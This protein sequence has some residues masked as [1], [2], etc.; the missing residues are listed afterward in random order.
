ML[1]GALA[2]IAVLGSLLPHSAAALT[3]AE[4]AAEAPVS[5]RSYIV[6]DKAS[7]QV[8]AAKDPEAPWIPA[9]M[10]KLITAMVVLDLKPVWKRTV[11]LERDDEVGGVRVAGRA[12]T[13]YTVKDLFYATLVP[14]ANNAANALAR[15]T[16]LSRGEFVA[17]MNEKA[18]TL[19]A[20]STSFVEP[21]GISELNITT[22]A[23]YARIVQAA[24]SHPD[25]RAAALT[26]RYT[27]RPVGAKAGQVLKN[28]NRLLHDP[29]LPFVG[30]KTGY[31]DES[32][33]N[34]AA[35]VKDRF[36]SE[37]VVVTLGSSTQKA[38]FEEVKQLV[39]FGGLSKAFPGSSGTVVLGTSTTSTQASVG[40][41]SH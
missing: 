32:R 19:G 37:F 18:L 40:T 15:S 24:L 36:G 26:E 11:R 16:G 4:L 39:A 30:G 6:L 5:A 17:R 33:Y 31:L 12:G 34:F 2:T 41:V 9:S 38:Q 13:R 14:S 1:K 27:V 21:S 35:E 25:I 23:D 28:T 29:D 3:V 7:G 10:T 8:L 20:R 22:A